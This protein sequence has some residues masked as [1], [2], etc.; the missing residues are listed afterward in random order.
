MNTIKR[1]LPVKIARK[2]IMNM[3]AELGRTRNLLTGVEI[4]GNSDS[5]DGFLQ[6]KREIIMQV[7]K[8]ALILGLFEEK[9]GKYEYFEPDIDLG[10][11]A[12]SKL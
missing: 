1:K 4:P 2:Y 11:E 7:D 3:Y 12:E 10:Y 8:M 5:I 6:N 9:V